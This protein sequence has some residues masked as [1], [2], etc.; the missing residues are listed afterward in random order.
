MELV[1]GS[2]VFFFCCWGSFGDLVI[3]RGFWG[4]GLFM[5]VVLCLFLFLRFFCITL[6]N[7]IFFIVFKFRNGYLCEYNI[8]S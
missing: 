8:F 6:V 1:V 4:G 3:V 7:C 5:F 2:F